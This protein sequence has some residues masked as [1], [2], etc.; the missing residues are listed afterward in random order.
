MPPLILHPFS[1]I[2]ILIE[3]KWTGKWKTQRGIE[4]GKPS[5]I[6]PMT[7]TV[8]TLP[9]SSITN[10]PVIQPYTASATDKIKYTKNK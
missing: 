9:Y 1:L 3:N 4:R 5:Q 6:A 10:H 2:Q 8:Q 7:D